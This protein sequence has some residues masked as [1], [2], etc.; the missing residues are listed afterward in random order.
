MI[1][2]NNRVPKGR[3]RDGKG[4]KEGMLLKGIQPKYYNEF[5]RSLWK[6]YNH[7][8]LSAII[9]YK[10]LRY[11]LESDFNINEDYQFG[12]GGSTAILEYSS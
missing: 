2:V 8:V 11:F 7:G 3:V 1:E 12:Q 10:L 6:R 9:L 5:Q 4:E